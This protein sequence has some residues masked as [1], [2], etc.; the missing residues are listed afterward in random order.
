MGGSQYDDDWVL[1]SADITLVLVGKLGCGKSATGNSILGQEVFASEYSHVSV[2]NTCQMGSTALKDG[3]TINVIDTP[4]PSV[5]AET[6]VELGDAIGS[7][8][9]RKEK[10]RQPEQMN[11]HMR[12]CNS[13]TGERTDRDS[14]THHTEEEGAA[15]ARRRSLTACGGGGRSLKAWSGEEVERSREPVATAAVERRSSARPPVATGDGAVERRGADLQR[16]RR[17]F[18]VDVTSED[19]GKEIVKC[20]KMAKD[21]FTYGDMIGESKL[22]NM[23][24]NAPE[25]L[26]KV[27]ELCQNRVVLFNNIT[28]DRRLQAQQLDKLLDLV[29]S[30]NANNGGKPFS[31]QMFTRIKEVHDREK[32]VHDRE[33]EMHSIGYSEKQISELKEEIHRT[34]DE[35][36][37]HITSMHV[38]P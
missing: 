9:Q 6:E 21:V 5:D 31:D 1:P 16:G 22:K 12:I 28:N 24:T 34:R 23:Q 19:A 4:G 38:E 8:K 18:D 32:E 26:K 37:K 25:C 29:D 13:G 30:I 27:I 17:L 15:A 36:L 11:Q 3:R 10:Q 2:T 33:K 35:Q 14:R 7:D 20:M